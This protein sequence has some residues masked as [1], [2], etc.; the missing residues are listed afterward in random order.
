MK[1][2][3]FLIIT[4]LLWT[5][6]LCPV[7]VLAGGKSLT[8]T[9]EQLQAL[10]VQRLVKYVKW[11][12]GAGPEPGEPYVIAATDSKKF[13]PY[14]NDSSSQF[15]LVQWPADGVHILVINGAPKREAAAILKRTAE[16][17]VLTIGQSPANLRQGVVINFRM[18][19]GKLKLQV[20]PHA[21][22]VAGL[23]ISSRLLRIATIY[24]G[25]AYEQ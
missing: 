14:F 13:K 3:Y 1:R 21:S 24:R 2:D 22:E 19:G 25:E 12:V 6:F 16:M 8:A 23:N 9:S 15:R 18:V 17:P 4:L 7:S 11:P 5:V 10:Y 20:N